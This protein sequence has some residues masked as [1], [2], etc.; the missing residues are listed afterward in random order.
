MYFEEGHFLVKLFACGIQKTGEYATNRWIFN[1]PLAV[2]A[3]ISAPGLVTISACGTIIGLHTGLGLSEGFQNARDFLNYQAFFVVNR[4]ATRRCGQQRFDAWDAEPAS[5]ERKNKNKTD[6]MRPASVAQ[7][8][9]QL[10]CNQQVVGSSPSAS[11]KE[12][13]SAVWRETVFM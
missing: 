7:P 1:S 11:L 2:E 13:P 3:K 9:E 5:V 10:I 12:K 4:R 6:F 8:A